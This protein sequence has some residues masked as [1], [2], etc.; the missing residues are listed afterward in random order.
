MPDKD[1]FPCH[2]SGGTRGVAGFNAFLSKLEERDEVD[3]LIHFSDGED[4]F[5]MEDLDEPMPDNLPVIHVFTVE[6]SYGFSNP[7]R[8]M[9]FGERVFIK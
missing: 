8:D 5:E 2:G 1:T 9:P 6:G 4:F 3:L 7:D